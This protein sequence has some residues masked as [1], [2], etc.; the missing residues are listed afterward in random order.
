MLTETAIPN[1]DQGF[2]SGGK[3]H[4]SRGRTGWDVTLFMT[5]KEQQ[6]ILKRIAK[7][8]EETNVLLR[9]LGIRIKDSQTQFQKVQKNVRSSKAKR[10]KLK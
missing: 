10:K 7:S 9:N 1:W 5:K 2:P 3:E 8:I 6:R 4:P